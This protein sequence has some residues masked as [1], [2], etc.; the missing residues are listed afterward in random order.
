M[1]NTRTVNLPKGFSV[2]LDM[3]E[4]FETRVKNYFSIDADKD[5]SDEQ[6]VYF[7]YGTLDNA[8]LSAE[9]QIENEMDY[10]NA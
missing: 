2:L 8:L 7:L 9:K 6:I 5:I 3:S 10:E 1:K 4:E